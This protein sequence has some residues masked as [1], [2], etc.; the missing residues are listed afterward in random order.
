MY[1]GIECPKGCP[2]K[3]RFFKGANSLMKEKL[4]SV[5]EQ[6]AARVSAAK[7]QFEQ[8]KKML[9]TNDLDFPGDFSDRKKSSAASRC[10]ETDRLCDL[11]G[12]FGDILADM[13]GVPK[14]TGK[15]FD[16]VKRQARE[17]QREYTNT[18]KNFKTDMENLQAKAVE[19]QKES[20]AKEKLAGYK[21]RIGEA[22]AKYLECRALALKNT[23]EAQ[24]VSDLITDLSEE[25]SQDCE[26][27]ADTDAG[28]KGCD[29]LHTN[30][31]RYGDSCS[32][33]IDR[34]IEKNKEPARRSNDTA[35]GG[36]DA[37]DAKRKS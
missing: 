9:G 1:A 22:R 6:F 34:Q 32:K 2:G 35:P 17:K 12:D 36:G 30:L 8:I 5:S 13:A 11:G 37:A 23:D 21:T 19:C 26:S 29:R 20:E 14:I 7:S 25:L 10:T 15:D 16:S 18:S 24:E 4:N 28:G 27:I 33:I 31:Q 3:K